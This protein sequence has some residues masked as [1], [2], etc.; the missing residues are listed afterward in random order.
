MFRFDMPDGTKNGGITTRP[1][2]LYWIWRLYREHN[3]TNLVIE[4]ETYYKEED[5]LREEAETPEWSPE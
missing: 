5:E 3:G 4:D 2:S 1:D